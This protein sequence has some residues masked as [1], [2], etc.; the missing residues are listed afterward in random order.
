MSLTKRQFNFCTHYVKSRN[1]SESATK[2]GYSVQYSQKRAYT[3]LNNKE[4]LERISE[5][6]ET[7]ISKQF[8]EL[9]FLAVQKLTDILKNDENGHTQL[10]SIKLIL[11]ASGIIDHRGYAD[12]VKPQTVFKLIN[13]MDIEDFSKE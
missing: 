11:Q 9:S 4:V 1:A 13:Y 2:A 3:L 8:Q 12:F 6:E 7:Y 5:L 10:S